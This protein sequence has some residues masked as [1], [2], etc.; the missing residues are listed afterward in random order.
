MTESADM[1]IDLEDLQEIMALL[2]ETPGG[3]EKRRNSLTRDDVLVIAKIVNSMSHKTCA[4][5]FTP[6]E[7]SKVKTMINIVNRGILG[8]GWL[9]VSTLVVAAMAG[10]GWAIKHGVIEAAETA[11]KGVGK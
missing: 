5:G 8:I 11:K 7:I 6:D 9:I 1:S 3:A 10:I 2:P 4:M